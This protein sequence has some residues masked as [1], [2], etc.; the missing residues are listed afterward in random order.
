MCAQF[1]GRE[2]VVKEVDTELFEVGVGKM[3][4]EGFE[5]IIVGGTSTKEAKVKRAFF[6]HRRV[7]ASMRNRV[8]IVDEQKRGSPHQDVSQVQISVEGVPVS[9]PYLQ[10]S[11]N[12][13]IQPET[14]NIGFTQQKQF[15]S[16]RQHA[17]K[18][19]SGRGRVVD[20]LKR[21]RVESVHTGKG[22]EGFLG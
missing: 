6:K 22:K 11:H 21:K 5:E 9:A 13:E 10:I 18:P 3:G 20:Q 14:T 12:F 2:T 4:G 16:P 1:K 17:L 7:D 15:S 19:G 8:K